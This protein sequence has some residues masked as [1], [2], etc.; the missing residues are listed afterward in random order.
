MTQ[1][2]P[3]TLRERLAF[4]RESLLA[5]EQA[6]DEVREEE[7]R[8]RIGSLA[9]LHTTTQ[10]TGAKN[11]RERGQIQDEWLLSDPEYDEVYRRL[12]NLDAAVKALR[13]QLEQAEDGWR[14][15]AYG[16]LDRLAGSGRV[17]DRAVE[18]AIR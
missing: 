15:Y 10:W 18:T 5:A 6:Q 3:M 11:D 1:G 13:V 9:A 7:R 17:T 2:P 12:R 14:E 8:A 16:V 4:A